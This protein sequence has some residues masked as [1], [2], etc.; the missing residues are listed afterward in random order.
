MSP[1][2][3]LPRATAAAVLAGVAMW[4]A[5]APVA[6]GPYAVAGVALLTVAVWGGSA[7]RGAGLGLLAGLLFFGLLLGWMRVIGWDAWLLLA[8]FWSLWFAF[9]GLGT[10][11]VTRLPG[12][13]VWV[14]S[15]WVLQEALRALVTRF[16]PPELPDG[17]APA[18]DLGIVAPDE[19]R[20]HFPLR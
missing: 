14:A 19:L 2:L 13:P 20:V 9:V 5:F 16:G 8:V 10:A 3:G 11:L 18:S 17:P 15:V 6:F 12:A 4:L 7:R 1:L